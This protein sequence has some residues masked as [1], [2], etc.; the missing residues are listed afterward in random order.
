MTEY[1]MAKVA[2]EIL[3]ADLMRSFPGLAISMPR[4]PRIQT[5]QTATV[6]PVPAA[7]ALDIMLP[8]LRQ[9]RSIDS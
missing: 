9:E 3:C 4:L 5:D 7:D 6:P 1:S 2:G 8:L